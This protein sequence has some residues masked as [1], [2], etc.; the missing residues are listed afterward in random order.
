MPS[1]PTPK[2]QND[3]Q[4]RSVS[5]NCSGRRPWR[6]P[7]LTFAQLHQPA[8]V[9]SQA[10]PTPVPGRAADP[11]RPR[12][13]ITFSRPAMLWRVAEQHAENGRAEDQP[14]GVDA[15]AEQEDCAND[16]GEHRR[17]IDQGGSRKVQGHGGHE[18]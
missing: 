12:P 9:H 6:A 11:K 16:D 1:L 17:N 3:P 13:Y 14:A 8:G 15:V 5:S 4:A 10:T 18:A 7:F 2:Q